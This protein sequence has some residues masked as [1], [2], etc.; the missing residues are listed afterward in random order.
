MRFNYLSYAL[1]LW[2]AFCA[3]GSL[4]AQ[5]KPIV[6]ATATMIA[7]MA[8]EI[9]GDHLD[10]KSIVPIGGDPHSY[11]PTPSDARLVGEADLV[12]VN[13]L[14]FE[15]WLGELVANS[16]TNAKVVTVT[17]GIVPITSQV[18]KNSEDPHAWMDLARGLTYIDNIKNAL[19]E[20]APE[21]ADGI[22]T[23]YQRYRDEA[24]ALDRYI[25]TEIQKIPTN[26]RIL[27]T[28]HDAFQY[29]GKRY[30]IRL[31]S[32][33]GTS[34]E[35]D[36]QTTDM[37]RVN[38]VI[39]ENNIPAV[40]IESTIAPRY[41]EQLAKDNKVKIGGKLYADSIGKKS[42]AAGSYLGMLRYN[43][44]TI[45]AA[46]SEVQSTEE[47]ETADAEEEGGNNFIYLLLLGALFIGGFFVVFRKLNV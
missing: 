41:L 33:M 13:G 10:V 25:M 21:H 37:I 31:E 14:T 39:K 4:A 36:V 43:T 20:L 22:E 9:A 45:V 40:F 19:V 11:E 8:Q 16:G 47:A 30:G 7:D 2:L 24:E 28:S 26:Q 17:E 1:T 12:L 15:G 29:Y 38:K 34:T 44:D 32:V 35:A 42:T 5:Q 23:N 3:I 46:L 18:Y 6:L 27:I